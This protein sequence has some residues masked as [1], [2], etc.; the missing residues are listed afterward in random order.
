VTTTTRSPIFRQGA[1]FLV[2]GG[3]SALTDAGIFWLLNTFGVA[4]WIAS[5]IS[6]MSAFV[7]NY[8]GN[9][10]LVFR[11]RKTRG[12][13]V[14]YCVLVVVNLGVSAAGVEVGVWL[15]AA[16]IVAKIITM[17][18]V[19]IVNFVAMRLWVFRHREDG[20]RTGADEPPH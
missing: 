7:I 9:R 12:T 5:S 3:L 19:A 18:V 14:R 11:S 16:P 20:N 4:P 13:L 8:R 17:V 15:G 6:F 10:D 2:V 1:L